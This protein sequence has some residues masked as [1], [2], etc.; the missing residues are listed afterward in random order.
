LLVDKISE[1]NLID[2]IKGVTSLLFVA[3]QQ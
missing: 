1:R 2:H 3:S